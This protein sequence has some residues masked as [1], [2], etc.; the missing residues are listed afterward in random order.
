MVEVIKAKLSPL[1]ISRLP[2]TYVTSNS[3]LL[4]CRQNCTLWL[5][6]RSEA[7]LPRRLLPRV[8]ICTFEPCRGPKRGQHQS[9]SLGDLCRA[10]VEPRWAAAAGG[11]PRIGCPDRSEQVSPPT[12]SVAWQYLPPPSLSLPRLVVSPQGNYFMKELEG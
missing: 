2:A 1:N 12:P 11:T 7:S 4:F 3:V 10:A 8:T 5:G 6:V 9:R